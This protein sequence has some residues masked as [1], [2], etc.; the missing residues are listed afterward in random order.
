MILP[1][2]PVPA[3]A[4]LSVAFVLGATVAVTLLVDTELVLLNDTLFHPTL[5][6][7]VA[8]LTGGLGVRSW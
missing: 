8:I 2:R 3:L 7:I 4:Y 6:G 5:F 1:R